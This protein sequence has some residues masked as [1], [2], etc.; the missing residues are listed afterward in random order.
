MPTSAFADLMTNAAIPALLSVFGIPATHINSEGDEVEVTIILEQQHDP[1]LLSEPWPQ[2]QW[3]IQ[4]AKATAA[5][6]GDTFVLAGTVTDEDPYPD[7]IT[8]QADTLLNDDGYFM[9]FT[10]RKV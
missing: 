10:A 4:V 1:L 9:T 6:P 2:R 7:D 3:T 8:W 5:V